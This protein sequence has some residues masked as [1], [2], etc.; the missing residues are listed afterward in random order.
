MNIKSI[1]LHNLYNNANNNVANNAIQSSS[2][3]LVTSYST[4]NIDISHI[5][6]NKQLY[7]DIA[8]ITQET[9]EYLE[10]IDINNIDNINKH[11]ISSQHINHNAINETDQTKQHILGL[12]NTLQTSD[13]TNLLH[14]AYTI[15]LILTQQLKN[16][17]KKQK[18]DPNTRHNTGFI[19]QPNLS[20][21]NSY[22]TTN[23]TQQQ[24]LQYV[25]TLPTIRQ[26]PDSNVR[27]IAL[28][29]DDSDNNV[30]LQQLQHK[31]RELRHAHDI[32]QYAIEQYIKRQRN[33]Q[34]ELTNNTLLQY[35]IYGLN[36]QIDRLQASNKNI[37]QQIQSIYNQHNH[38]VQ[39]QT[40]G[41]P[42]D[43]IIQ[44]QIQYDNLL[45]ANTTLVEQI[46]Q[47]E[48]ELEQLQQQQQ[49][50]QDNN[51]TLDN[52]TRDTTVGDDQNSISDNN[53]L[54]HGVTDNNNENINNSNITV[55]NSTNN[56]TND[57]LKPV[58]ESMH[59]RQHRSQ[60]INR[61]KIA[62]I[63]IDNNN[64][65]EQEEIEALLGHSASIIALNNKQQQQQQQQA[66]LHKRYS[67]LELLSTDL[68]TELNLVNVSQTL[69]H[70]DNV[71]K[72]IQLQK[73][74]EQDN[75]MLSNI[76]EQQYQPIQQKY[77]DV[78]TKHDTL[79]Q[80]IT[81]LQQRM[82]ALAQ[83]TKLNN[84]GS[85]TMK[86]TKHKQLQQTTKQ[87]LNQNNNDTVNQQVTNSKDYNNSN[88]LIDRES[89]M[90]DI[91]QLQ[92][93]LKLLD[94]TTRSSVNNA[95]N[96]YANQSN[97]D[98][99]QQHD[100]TPQ[101]LHSSASAPTL[102]HA[103]N[104]K[105]SNLQHN[106][107]IVKNLSISP[108]EQSIINNTVQSINIDDYINQHIDIVNGNKL[109]KQAKLTYKQLRNAIKQLHNDIHNLTIA[110]RLS[111]PIV[112]NTKPTVDRQNTL[113]QHDIDKS[114]MLTPVKTNR[115]NIS[116][117]PIQTQSITT[118][119]DNNDKNNN[120]ANSNVHKNKRYTISKSVHMLP[121]LSYDS[122]THTS[123][124]SSLNDM[125]KIVSPTSTTDVY[126]SNAMSNLSSYLHTPA[127]Q[128]KPSLLHKSYSHTVLSRKSTVPNI[129]PSISCR[130]LE[131]LQLVGSSITNTVD[132]NS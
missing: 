54:N 63:A 60:L 18:T 128:Y 93:E 103:N 37:E 4:N 9:A 131:S 120:D 44:L 113:L 95:N 124:V 76:V 73:R 27:F 115:L 30:A 90:N 40:N 107:P 118:M 129:L 71:P 46:Q 117:S 94:S 119:C 87:Q 24:S 97:V 55:D 43:E 1:S 3:H 23:T 51:I 88:N 34:S 69:Q 83:Q 101:L 39:C 82:Q 29:E 21:D 123:S 96:N 127:T 109:L 8:H 58:T 48:N 38:D 41:E 26:S 112:R 105:P 64:D 33:I 102:T 84:H 31:Y 74:T 13:S 86:H 35:D 79:Q 7:T 70:L 106:N 111:Q 68:P 47:A 5:H 11:D 81:V 100:N 10:N 92:S 6:N 32:Q 14:D 98:T 130:Q 49:H 108:S 114:A 53:D 12:L 122:M 25:S 132:A 45:A 42:N 80:L 15:S 89:L 61:N 20:R 72:L 22:S 19:Q 116:L 59:S 77:N 17:D 66:T 104:T 62:Y 126:N 67:S 78:K 85:N 99:T 75:L 50:Q 28:K 91:E 36:E 125:F 57:T 121:P 110:N 2:N 16:V 65:N 52:K 56:N